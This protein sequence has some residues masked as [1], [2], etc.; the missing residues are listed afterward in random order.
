M[1]ICKKM[2]IEFVQGSALLL[3]LCW[4]QTVNSRLWANRS[5][6]R[7]GAAGLLFGGTCIVGMLTSITLEPGLIFDGRTAVLS[8][9]GLFGGPL[10]AVLAGLLAGAYRL[11]LGGPGVWVGLANV[12]LPLLLGVLY[13][14]YHRQGK[15]GMGAWQLL[16]FGLLVSALAVGLLALLP[17]AQAH[18]SLA[19]LALPMLTV[20]PLATLLLGLL[21]KDIPR[22]EAIESALRVGEARQRAISGAIPDLFFVF[23][24]DGRYLEIIA[25]EPSLLPCASTE[26]I[27]RRVHEVLP[28]PE[29]QRCLGFIQ[30]TLVNDGPQLLEYR[31]HTLA[32]PKVFEGRAQRIEGLLAGKRV[33]ALLAR[34]VSE[35]SSVELERRIAAIAFES[36]QG[37]VITDSNN[38]ILRVNQAFTAISGYSAAEVLGQHT[39]M[40]NSGRQ[41]PAFYQAMW[42][43]IEDTSAWQGEVW[44][45]RKNGDVFPEWLSISAVR[46][47]QGRVC[48]YVAALTDTSEHK[49]AADQIKY[50]AFFDPLTELPNRRLLLDRLQHA[51]AA[52]VRSG[53]FAAL[54]FL[55]LDNF[56]N[57][58][59]LYGHQTGDKLLCLVAERLRGCVRSCDTVARLG[60]D[61]FVL[62]LES[63]KSPPA[64]AASQAEQI[65]K[66]I[67]QV[68]SEPYQ[69]DQRELRSSASIGLLLFNDEHCDIHEL[70][71]RADLSMYEAKSAGKNALRFFD[72]AMQ[73]AVSARL[74]LE[75][76]IRQGLLAGEFV[77]HL[78]PQMDQQHGLVGAEALARWQHPQRGLL[79]PAAFIEVAERAGLIDQLDFQMLQQACQQLAL[80]AGQA[81]T[82]KLRLAVNLS[83]RLLYQ[84]DFVERLLHLLDTS[85]A[86]PACLKLELTETLLLDDL[87]GAVVRMTALKAR[88]IR[89]SI[90]DFGTGYSS[91]LYLQRLPLDQLKI[92]QSFVRALPGDDSSLAIIHAICSL[93]ASLKLEVIAEGVETAAQHEL[94]LSSGCRRFQGYLFGRPMPLAEF[95]RLPGCVLPAGGFDPGM[96][97]NRQTSQSLSAH[98]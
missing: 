21:L 96:A 76:E 57:I 92:D 36:Q 47:A 3:A 2:M 38:I 31:M 74:Q 35:R 29:G 12:L 53:Q 28:G 40:L 63:L 97:L 52:S 71:Q 30:R 49:A 90:D 87:P 70:M 41:S 98:C 27:G 84:D 73:D 79:T 11:W 33:V 54:L 93:A 24:E 4:L 7:Q 34:D 64:E 91:M 85:G 67:L 6:L 5:W 10:V 25:P 48:N 14:H 60:G 23:D 65:G 32:G 86:N 59:D 1:R 58:N 78:Q 50:L 13:W 42:R 77:M 81:H 68:L 75:E 18:L 37:M 69:I 43:S 62:L 72:P 46:D 22:R 61:E 44:N 45:R 80:W 95:I 17:A 55:D 15:L 89:F 88:G 83:A 16:S 19:L 39:R 66:K 26:L 20:L 8:M 82:A 51:Q 94:L 9:A 56:K